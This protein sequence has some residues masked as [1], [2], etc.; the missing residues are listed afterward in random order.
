MLHRN[1]IPHTSA[2]LRTALPFLTHAR[3]WGFAEN[4]GK[5]V[6]FHRD[7]ME[8][9]VREKLELTLFLFLFHLCLSL[10]V[11]VNSVPINTGTSLEP[12]SRDQHELIRD[13][14]GLS[15]YCKL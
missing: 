6:A 2:F 14:C 3:A 10:L 5:N 15:H 7:K 9:K 8:N 13:R 4:Q 12:G 1:E 11:R